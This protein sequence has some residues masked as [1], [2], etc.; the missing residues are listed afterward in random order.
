MAHV[1]RKHITF[2]VLS[3][4]LALSSMQ[5]AIAMQQNDPTHQNFIKGRLCNT[6]DGYATFPTN[7]ESMK[8]DK[9]DGD[10]VLIGD[11]GK[12]DRISVGNFDHLVIPGDGV[13]SLTGRFYVKIGDDKKTNATYTSI[14]IND[15]QH[16]E[17]FSKLHALEN[18]KWDEGI[19]NYVTRLRRGDK[20]M[21]AIK[22]DSSP[23]QYNP[24]YSWLQVEKLHD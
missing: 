7:W 24:L 10:R 11:A 23:V 9:F 22:G 4:C 12:P 20:I 15:F 16:A 17:D 1:M 6:R 13:Y 2:F 18:H 8:F 21:L 19:I 3:L 14:V 5:V